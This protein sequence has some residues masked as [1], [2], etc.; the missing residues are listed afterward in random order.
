MQYLHGVGS[1]FDHDVMFEFTSHS[2]SCQRGLIHGSLKPN[3][4]LIADNGQACVS[5]YGMIEIKPSASTG[6]RYFSPEAWKG[7]CFSEDKYFCILIWP[8]Y[9]RFL[10]PRMCLLLG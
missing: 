9:R 7:V 6:T 8:F 5:D 2:L 1:I 3:N 10:G 4:I